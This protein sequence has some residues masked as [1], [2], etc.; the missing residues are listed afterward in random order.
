MCISS[1][2]LY[3]M[4]IFLINEFLINDLLIIINCF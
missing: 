3:F 4:L 1:I 2:E